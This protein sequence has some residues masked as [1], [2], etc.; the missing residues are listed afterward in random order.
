VYVVGK[1]KAGEAIASMAH[2]IADMAKETGLRYEFIAMVSA[3]AVGC[4][5]DGCEGE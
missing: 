3:L 5:I 4:M 2:L 1:Y